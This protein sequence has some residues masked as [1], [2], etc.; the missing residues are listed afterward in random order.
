MR[1]VL[2][3]E[4]DGEPVR[5]SREGAVSQLSTLD[6]SEAAA[7]DADLG[8]GAMTVVSGR[9]FVTDGA[10]MGG[11]SA[12]GVPMRKSWELMAGAQ[13]EQRRFSDREH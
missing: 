8:F 5:V 11:S 10:V 4:R 1:A 12:S 13:G 2:L 9:A 6:S 7:V 3:R